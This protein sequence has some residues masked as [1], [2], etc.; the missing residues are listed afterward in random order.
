MLLEWNEVVDVYFITSTGQYF[1]LIIG[2][3]TFI[4][5]I[6]SLIQQEAVSNKTV[7]LIGATKAN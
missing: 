6:W 4:S 5:V 3:G 2:T 1:A 7:Q